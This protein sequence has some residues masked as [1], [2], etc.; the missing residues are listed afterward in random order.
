M[1]EDTRL[2]ERFEQEGTFD[3]FGDLEIVELLLELARCPGKKTTLAEALIDEF[4]SLKGVLEAREEQLVKI[5]GIG[6]RT[7]STIRMILPF[8]RAWE[9]ASLTDP[10]RIGNPKEAERYCKGLLMGLRNEQFYVI[11][12]NRRCRVLGRRRISEGSLSEV[13]AYPRIIVE[14]AL[15]YN[16]NSV[17][18]CHNHPGGTKQP[19]AE[20]ISST[21]VL[22]RL[23]GSVGIPVL[24][25]IIVAGNGCYSMI[26]HGDICYRKPHERSDDI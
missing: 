7:A 26:Q 23:L 8:V 1:V 15:N 22:Q 13:N 5:R 25:H 20:D 18:L 11:C 16:A 14:T 6:R 12:L 2:L 10:Q 21:L 9:K 4:G 17:L 19:S 24:D 3:F